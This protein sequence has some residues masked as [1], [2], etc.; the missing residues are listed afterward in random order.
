MKYG[1]RS[2]RL[3]QFICKRRASQR[4]ARYC[5]CISDFAVSDVSGERR[6]IYTA[7][8]VGIQLAADVLYGSRRIRTK[9]AQEDFRFDLYLGLKCNCERR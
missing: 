2:A 1:R 5:S 6:R 3:L 7:A 4:L 9:V 8:A